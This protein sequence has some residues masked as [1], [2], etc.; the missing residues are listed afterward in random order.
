VLDLLTYAGHLANLED[1]DVEFVRG[2]VCDAGLLAHVVP[3]HDLVV[4]FAA[5]SHVDTS[6][7]DGA[8]FVRTNVLGVETLMRAC[9]DARVRSVVQVSTD[10]VYGSVEVGSWTEDAPLAPSSPYA[11]TKAGGDLV[12]LAYHR[13]HGLPVRVTRCGNNYGPYQH[14][15]KLIPRFVTNVL[16]GRPLPLYGDGANVREWIHVDDHCRAIRLVA[17]RGVP[18]E[19]YHV[20]GTTALTNRELTGRLLAALGAD[21]S[22]VKPVADRPG[23]DQRYSLSDAKLR[24]LGYAPRVAFEEGF[25]ETVA[26]YVR[27]EAWWRP[28]LGL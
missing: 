6:I 4:N 11:A 28:L 27:N 17:A 1:A 16:T 26:W 25:A 7:A 24:A 13:T 20:A 5:E 14:P 22:V 3:G 10:E 15:E 18:G 12:A 8:A 19:V 21:W 2:D 9:V 23:H